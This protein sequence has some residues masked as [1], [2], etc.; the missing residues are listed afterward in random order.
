MSRTW[1]VLVEQEQV[2]AYAADGL[3]YEGACD[4]SASGTLD[5]LVRTL[6]AI[7]PQPTSLVLVVGLAWLDVAAVSLPPVAPAMQRRMLQ[8]DPDRVFAVGEPVAVTISGALALAAPTSRLDAWSAALSAV[9]PV[10]AA[11]AL[12]VAAA[13]AAQRGTWRVVAARGEQGLVIVSA[14]AGG[15]RC[16][17]VRRTR[18]PLPDAAW[19]DLRA[20]ATAVLDA[21]A[22]PPDAQ[23]LDAPREAAY[24]RATRTAWW[25]AGLLAGSAAV[26]ALWSAAQW[27]ERVLRSAEAQAQAL[28]AQ[29][30]PAL[31]AQARLERARREREFLATYTHTATS[32]TQVLATLGR[33]LPND[34]F[35][36]RAAWDGVAWRVDGSADDAASLVPRLDGEALFEGVR[37]LAPSTRYLERGRTRSSFSIGF[38]VKAAERTP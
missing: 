17:A 24:A 11:V 19:L 35:V 21:A 4:L 36:Q 16:T 38:S 23:L 28:S 9:A 6:Q 29:A 10:R 30:G 37:S 15:D 25:R 22:L 18:Q 8:L 34:V 12:P 33:V 7:S 1:A 13:L 31:D 5:T 3:V 2:R 27:R 32:P 14:N 20:C 26:F